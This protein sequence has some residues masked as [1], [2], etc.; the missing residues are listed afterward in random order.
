MH[1]ITSR[2]GVMPVLY[3]NIMEE[4]KLSYIQIGG[5][6]TA[7]SFASGFP[8]IFIS[9]LRRRFLGKTLIGVGNIILSVMNAASNIIKNFNQFI[10]CRVIGEIRGSPQ[11]PIGTSILTKQSPERQRG[12]VLGLNPAAA[13]LASA[14]APLIGAALLISLGW[15]FAIFSCATPAFIV[16]LVLIFFAHETVDTDEQ[17]KKMGVHAFSE[18]FLDAIR[19]RNVLAISVVRTVVAFRM[20]G[21]AFIPLYFIN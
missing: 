19:D 13:N 9:F 16:A 3:P 17:S 1:S 20:G 4:L 18:A 10:F 21:R 12:R 15:R 2:W 11:H 7:S 6:R 5:I 14:I 8:Q